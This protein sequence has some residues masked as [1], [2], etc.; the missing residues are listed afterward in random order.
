M[1]IMDEMMI[2][3]KALK[4]QERLGMR[5][6]ISE[7][8][9]KYPVIRKFSDAFSALE[10][11]YRTGLK[12]FVLPYNLFKDIKSATD[13]YKV[14]Y[15]ELIRLKDMAQKYNIELS[16]HHPELTDQP[17]QDLKLLTNVVGIM[18]ARTLIIHPNFYSRMPREQAVKLV[19]YK[20]N[21][22][23][24]SSSASVKI[25]VETTGNELGSLED[26]IEIVKRSRRTE[27]ALNWAH[28]HARGV[29]ALR[30]EGDFKTVISNVASGL[31]RPWLTNAYFFFS[32]ISYGPSGE[33][34]HI[35]LEKSDINLEYLIRAI[36]SF[37]IKGT[38]IFED[39]EKEKFILKMLD[40][41][42]NMV[43]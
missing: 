39:P 1:R 2:R 25:A 41:L 3:K 22:I 7:G 28:I 36:M 11:S 24:A 8:T 9:S 40:S 37:N 20:L 15:G 14:K 6:G 26:V 35:P 42:A 12:A 18:D 10:T 5:I 17:D 38:L 19:V 23:L 33:L 34:K 16:V 27:P 4:I 31:G 43:R 21:E 32:G 29:G 30:T 13:L